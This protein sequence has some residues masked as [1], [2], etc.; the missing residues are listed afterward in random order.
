MRLPSPC[1]TASRIFAGAIVFSVRLSAATRTATG[2]LSAAIVWHDGQSRD[3]A[4]ARIAD[5]QPI[6]RT[7]SG[8]IRRIICIARKQP[9]VVGCVPEPKAKAASIN[10]GRL[11]AGRGVV[12]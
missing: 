2:S 4:I 12:T 5:P 1:E 9:S 10:K 8:T 11:A 7:R 3:A 6:S